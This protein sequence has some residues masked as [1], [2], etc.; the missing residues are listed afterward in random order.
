[1]CRLCRKKRTPVPPAH[2]YHRRCR[3]AVNMPMPE[4]TRRSDCGEPMP[5]DWRPGAW[6]S[7]I[8]LTQSRKPNR[9]CHFFLFQ[10]SGLQQM[11]WFTAN[12]LVYS[13][14]S[15]LRIAWRPLQRRRAL[16]S[17]PNI[18][19]VAKVHGVPQGA[20][21]LVCHLAITAG[22]VLSLKVT[23]ATVR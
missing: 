3:P 15:Y 1:M 6:Q 18:R 14:S 12:V 8:I 22:A 19:A 23:T 9:R 21:A 5:P 13:T 10:Y 4:L 2:G 17:G 11:F 7:K 16:R 20:E